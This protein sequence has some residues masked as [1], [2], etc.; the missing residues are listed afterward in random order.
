M[1][2]GREETRLNLRMLLEEEG[3]EETADEEAEE[4]IFSDEEEAESDSEKEPTDDK[5]EEEAEEEA[6]ETKISPE[7]E[8]V[9]KNPLEAQV[10]SALA[11]IE[12]NALK[13]AKVNEVYTGSIKRWL[14]ESDST[15]DLETFASETS[16]LIQNYESL[17]DI[18]SAIYHRAVSMLQKNYG[19][20]VVDTFKE[21]M[22]DQYGY[23]F[24]DVRPDP[25]GDIA[26][27]ALG[28]AG[29]G[30]GGGV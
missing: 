3:E 20:D 21:I 8:E 15:I 28:S 4:D 1:K 9:L 24:G 27:L 25:V 11:D 12:S 6:E 22:H 18:E 23:D 13:S 30:G 2:Y 7:E 10:D 16:R 19:A 26:P 17:L 5:K 14:F 29:E